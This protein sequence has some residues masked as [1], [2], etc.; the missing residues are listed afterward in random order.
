MFMQHFI[1]LSTAVHELS[2]KQRQ[3]KNR[4][5]TGDDAEN[6]TAFASASVINILSRKLAIKQPLKIRQN[7][8]YLVGHNT[9]L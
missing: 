3:R 4:M 8:I 9:K 6:N 1:K 2:C 5:I 7:T